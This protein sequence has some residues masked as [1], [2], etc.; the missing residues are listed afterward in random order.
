MRMERMLWPSVI[1]QIAPHQWPASDG[2][3]PP[4]HYRSIL[5]RGLHTTTAKIGCRHKGKRISFSCREFSSPYL[6]KSTDFVSDASRPVGVLIWKTYD[7]CPSPTCHCYDVP[8]PRNDESPIVRFYEPVLPCDP[9]LRKRAHSRRLGSCR[10]SSKNPAY[11][12]AP[13]NAGHQGPAYLDGITYRFLPESAVRTGA[14]TSGQVDV[15][16]GISG[17]GAALFKDNPDFTYQSAVNTGTP[18]TLYLNVTHGPTVDVK[19]R[20]AVLAAID[21]AR[22]IES[23]Y[24]GERTRAWGILTPA[25]TDFYDKSRGRCRAMASGKA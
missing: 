5:I 10:A 18:Y 7:L 8:R 11:N 21:V 2:G 9:T 16:E 13:A 14:L 6:C 1:Q 3:D 20:K 22:V 24:R 4:Q 17:N 25:D 12:W 19:V 15:I 23:V